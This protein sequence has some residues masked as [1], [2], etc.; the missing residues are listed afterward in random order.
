MNT[1]RGDAASS[2]RGA[3]NA[4]DTADE[5]AAFQAIPGGAWAGGESRMVGA[6]F[7]RDDG[8]IFEVGRWWQPWG[9]RFWGEREGK[10]KRRRKEKIERREK[11]RGKKIISGFRFLVRVKNP[12][13]Y[14]SQK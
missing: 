10:E 4:R 7:R 12:I 5:F 6:T 8:P 2:R 9:V 1:R 14:S 3:L 13:L 11:E